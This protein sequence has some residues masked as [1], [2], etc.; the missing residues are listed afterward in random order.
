MHPRKFKYQSHVIV[1]VG[2]TAAKPDWPVLSSYWSK[3]HSGQNSSLSHSEKIDIAL[4]LSLFIKHSLPSSVHLQSWL[5]WTVP[6]R[7]SFLS[8]MTKV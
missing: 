3:I 6:P 8:D 2:S 4:L 5:I 1:A 7:P